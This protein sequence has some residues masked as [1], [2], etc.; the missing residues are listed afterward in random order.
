MLTIKN[1]LAEAGKK[2]VG[3][4][5]GEDIK[6]GQTIWV[7]DSNF[8]K[9]YHDSDVQ[10]MPAHQQEFIKRY[11]YT[12]HANPSVWILDLDNGRFMNHDDNPNSDYDLKTGWA[13][14]DIKKGE[15]ITCDYRVFD[16][17]KLDFL[18]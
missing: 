2:G 16:T 14:K 4:F 8:S 1:Y 6:K 5:A 9:S 11:A 10:K 13:T 17:Q 12:D 18:S 3:V 7:F 15:E